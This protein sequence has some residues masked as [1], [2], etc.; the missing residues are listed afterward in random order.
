MATYGLSLSALIS[1]SDA[2]AALHISARLAD[3]EVF[4]GQRMPIFAMGR[5]IFARFRSRP[6]TSDGIFIQANWLKMLRI[7]AG[8]IAAEM[9][10]HEACGNSIAQ[11]LEYDAM[12]SPRFPF[13]T[14]EHGECSISFAVISCKPRPAF[15]RAASHKFSF[16]SLRQSL[17]CSGH[18]Y[19]LAYQTATGAV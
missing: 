19:I 11:E 1:S 9:I 17:Y 10:Q 16:K 15:V 7:Y 6:S 13:A 3:D 18:N 14:D 8:L 2:N 5:T 4:T 12:G